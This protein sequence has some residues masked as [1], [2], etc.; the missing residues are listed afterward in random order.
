MYGAL[1]S[2]EGPR[3]NSG[4]DY[5]TP[6]GKALTGAEPRLLNPER[7]G[8]LEVLQHKRTTSPTAGPNTTLTPNRPSM[9]MDKDQPA[10]MG[11]ILQEITAVSHRIEG[12]DASISSL[13]LETKSMRSDIASFQS[14]MTGLEPRVGTLET[15]VTTIQDRDQDLSYLRSKLTDLEDRSRRDNI[16]LFEILENEEGPDVQAFLSSVL[17]KLTSLTFEPPVEFHE[18]TEWARN[19]LM[20]PQ[21]PARSLLACYVTPRPANSFK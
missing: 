8:L 20:G 15:H 2:T 21:Y 18:H 5:C 1:I 4:K 12:M 16:R 7:T 13:T 9:M 11:R 17:P 3:D 14:R 10:T 19:A 6:T